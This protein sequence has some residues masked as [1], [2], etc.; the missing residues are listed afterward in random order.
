MVNTYPPYVSEAVRQWGVGDAAAKAAAD[1]GHPG[2]PGGAKA[3]YAAWGTAHPKPRATLAQV[4][5][6]IDHIVRRIGVDHVGIGGD[7]DGIE[8][9]AQGMEDVSTYGALFTE[10]ARRGYSKADL[11]K[12]SS[13]NMLRVLKA[14]EDYA[15]SAR[16]APPA[17][18]PT[19]F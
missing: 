11:E 10:L 14:A 3:E 12:I 7:F 6:H 1:A 5:D 19:S 2:D 17:E 4:A 13:G 16:A 18:N 15:A 8:D 9:T